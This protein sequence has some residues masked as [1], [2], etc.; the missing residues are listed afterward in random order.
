MLNLIKMDLYRLFH[1]KAIKVGMIAS[2]IVAFVGMLFNFGIISLIEIVPDEDGLATGWLGMIF[3]A[4]N[5]IEGVDFASIVISGTNILSLF[6][7]C[8]VSASFI[9]AE[10]SC[11]YVKNIAGQLHDRGYTVI[12]KFAV[13][14]LIH[15]IVLLIY[16]LVSTVCAFVFFSKYIVAYSV[17][18]LIAGFLLRLLLFIA[19]NAVILFLCTLTKSQSLAMVTGAIFGIGVTKI[20]YMIANM[21]LKMLKISINITNFMPDGINGELNFGTIETL[22][23]KAIIVS[24][25]F[26]AIFLTGATLLVKKRDVK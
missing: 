25:V 13:T 2:V 18:K 24:V 5:W 6:I 17:G 14:S 16:A 21:I 8:M 9:S 3:P 19:I 15:F 12:S 20:F 4:A 23:V 11:G 7:G 1:S 10:Q 26:I 22:A